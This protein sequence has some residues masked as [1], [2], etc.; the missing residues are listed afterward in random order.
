[1]VDLFRRVINYLIIYIFILCIMYMFENQEMEKYLSRSLMTKTYVG[2]IFVSQVEYD[3][4]KNTPTPFI[5]GL[6]S[7][8]CDF[9]LYYVPFSRGYRINLTLQKLETFLQHQHNIYCIYVH[10]YCLYIN[11]YI[12]T[13][14]EYTE[15]IHRIYK[16]CK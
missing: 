10:M 11:M 7:P 8:S 1:M 15:P 5:F 12:F 14:K 13:K 3:M 2:Y 9:P 16:L 6:K 4:E